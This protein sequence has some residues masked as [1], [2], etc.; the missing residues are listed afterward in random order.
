MRVTLTVIVVMVLVAVL[1]LAHARLVAQQPEVKLG[2]EHAFLKEAEGVW[3]ATAKS[4][5]NESRAS[6]IARCF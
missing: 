5:G 3:D 1:P 4:M 6:C 2:P